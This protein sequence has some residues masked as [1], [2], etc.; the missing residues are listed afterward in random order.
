MHNHFE[1]K[2]KK[3]KSHL[4]FKNTWKRNSLR[5]DGFPLLLTIKDLA[6]IKVE[7]KCSRL[8][9]CLDIHT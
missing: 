7:N 8:S 4:S 3:Q 5:K 9:I 1:R 2:N 6:V